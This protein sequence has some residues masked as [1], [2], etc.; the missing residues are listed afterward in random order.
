M[1]SDANMQATTGLP[2]DLHQD[3]NT[4][5]GSD[6][7]EPESESNTDV[8]GLPVMT[9]QLREEIAKGES[10]AFIYLRSLT[11]LVLVVSAISVSLCVYFDMTHTEKDEFEM[12]YH[13]DAHKVLESV[14]KALDNTLGATDAFIVKMM[15]YAD[16]SNSTWPFVT[17]PHFAVQA[18]KLL[19]LSKAFKMSV[20]HIVQ[21]EQRAE[22]QE[23][24]YNND[25]WL[26]ES[27][28]IQ[29]KDEDWKHS[30]DR[31]YNT[32]YELFGFLPDSSLGPIGDPLPYMNTYMPSWQAAPMVPNLGGEYPYNRD[33][34]HL[35]NVAAAMLHAFQNQRIVFSPTFGNIITDPD[36]QMQERIAHTSRA[37][38]KPYIDPEENE[39]EPIFRLSCFP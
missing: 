17:M 3:P 31:V 34:W 11:F 30:I 35:M 12:Q 8:D 33:G 29:E 24:A 5:H 26:E 21:P 10:K 2:H 15:A 4:D 22:W 38:S 16:S 14:G 28:D 20:N 18:T 37:W 19:K 32:S 1:D 7:D 13:S 27:L 39:E 36:D 25:G 23:Y 9:Q 6:E